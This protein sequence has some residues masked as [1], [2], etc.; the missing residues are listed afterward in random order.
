[1]FPGQKCK[2]NKHFTFLIA[3]QCSKCYLLSVLS[4]EKI[5]ET[6]SIEQASVVSL[7]AL[8]LKDAVVGKVTFQHTT[9]QQFC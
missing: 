2:V 3:L 6:W 9:K 7:K 8:A 4:L 5:A 1:M